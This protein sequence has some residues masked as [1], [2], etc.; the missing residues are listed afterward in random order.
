LYSERWHGQFQRSLP[1]ERPIH[2]I[3]RI[4]LSIAIAA[5]V[6]GVTVHPPPVRLR[7]FVMEA[8][9]ERGDHIDPLLRQKR[10]GAGIEPQLF[11][12]VDLPEC[13]TGRVEVVVDLRAGG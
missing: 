10:R 2:H 13:L 1:L 7:R 6:N 3:I 9:T 11:G 5:E 4:E 8:F 12:S